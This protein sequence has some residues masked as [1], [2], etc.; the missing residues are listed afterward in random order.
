[1]YINNFYREDYGVPTVVNLLDMV[2]VFRFAVDQG[3]VAVHCHA[4][5]G[6]HY[7]ESLDHVTS[8][9]PL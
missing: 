2:K 5:L 8:C 1:M 3:K 7:L 9:D 4:G 6:K